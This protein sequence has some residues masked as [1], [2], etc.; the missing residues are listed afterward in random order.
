MCG[1]TDHVFQMGLCS[2]AK[3]R[4]SAETV[5]TSVRGELCIAEHRF[6]HLQTFPDVLV[7][8]RKSLMRV[9]FQSRFVSKNCSSQWFAAFTVPEAS[10]LLTQRVSQFVL[11]HR[12][13]LWLLLANKFVL[14]ALLV[15]MPCSKRVLPRRFF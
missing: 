1:F 2:R 15:R 10:G 7:S 5:S 9:D 13:L 11:D 12:P 3:A 6:D 8:G 4:R 14:F